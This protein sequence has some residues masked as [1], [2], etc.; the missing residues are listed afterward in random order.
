MKNDHNAVSIMSCYTLLLDTNKKVSAALNVQSN[1]HE[2]QHKLR[3]NQI[4]LQ[5][6]QVGLKQS[7]TELAAAIKTIRN[8]KSQVHSALTKLE[9]GQQALLKQ[10]QGVHE[11]NQ[12]MLSAYHG[13][14]MVMKDVAETKEQIGALVS[15]ARA[16][17][18]TPVSGDAGKCGVKQEQS[19]P[20][21]GR[22]NKQV[23]PEPKTGRY[24]LRRLRRRV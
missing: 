8:E 23:S 4:R 14:G 17:G 24:H 22:S 2:A 20:T 21:N 18:A 15:H 12:A 11:A 16:L 10:V 9:L 7:D 1:Q 6:N 13:L 19:P 3:E 5:A